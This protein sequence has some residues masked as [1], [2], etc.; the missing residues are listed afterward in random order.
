MERGV[1]SRRDRRRRA[2]AGLTLIE[3]MIVVLI[4]AIAAG[5]ASYAFGALERTRLRSACMRIAA[6]ARYAYH[7]SISRGTTVRLLFDLDAETMAFEEAHGRITLARA[8]DP[9]REEV[10]RRREDG[11]EDV[12]GV[13]PWAAARARL[14]NTLRPSFGGSPFTPLEGRRYAPQPVGDGISIERLIVPHEP[15]P[16]ER[17]R[18]SIYFFPGGLTEHAVI[19]LSDGEDQIHSVEVHPLTGRTRVYGYAYEPD[20]LI[21]PGSERPANEVDD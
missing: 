16:R 12:S 15:S 13:D 14:E 3:M 8:D 4:V 9:R 11:S 6:A 19:W 17:G 10:A 7:R 1:R 5:G 18:G 2:Q 21:D 20:E